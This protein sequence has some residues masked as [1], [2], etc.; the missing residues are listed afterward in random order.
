MFKVIIDLQDGFDTDSVI[1]KVDNHEIFNKC[2]ISTQLLL[3]IAETLSIDNAKGP[4]KISVEIPTKNLKKNIELYINKTT[5][6]GISVKNDK[7][8]VIVSNRSF[9]YA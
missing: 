7:I 3:G 5:Y 8:H 1:I 4:L 9:G 2:Q 6:V